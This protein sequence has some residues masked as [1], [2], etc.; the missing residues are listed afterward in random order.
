MGLRKRPTPAEFKTK[1]IIA[2]KKLKKREARL[3]DDATRNRL[4]AKE[5]LKTGDERAFRIVSRR[6]AVAEGQRA[7][8]GNLLEMASSIRDLIEMQEQ[9]NEVVRISNDLKR[10]HKHLGIDTDR[11]EA[12]ISAI[13]GS[14][15]G[16]TVASEMIATSME[17]LGEVS[18]GD[19]ISEDE[20]RRELLA[21]IEM[22]VDQ[23]EELEARIK[24]A[25]DE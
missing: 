24:M 2:E 8:V 16:V 21:E 12:A 10:F 7:S 11:L 6:F 3:T 1:I 14:M 22:D 15:T 9:M 23:T 25:K 17:Y 20:L 5:A 4:Q 18:P 13:S 19:S